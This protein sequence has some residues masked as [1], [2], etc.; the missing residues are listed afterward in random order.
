MRLRADPPEFN[1]IPPALASHSSAHNDLKKFKGQRIAVIGAGQSALESAALC[2]E[3]GAEVEVIP[4]QS[5]SQLGG[6]ASSPAPSG[7]CVA[8]AL[9]ETRRRSS[10]NQQ[11][12]GGAPPVSEVPPLVSGSSHVPRNSTGRG[13]LAATSTGGYTHYVWA[14]GNSCHRYGRSTSPEAR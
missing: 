4:R 9:F 10:W 6:D 1:E 13:G 5:Y 2:R 8:A 3:E 7:T 12:R 11:T 14:Q